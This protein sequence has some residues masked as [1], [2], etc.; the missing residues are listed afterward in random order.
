MRL[1]FDGYSIGG[2]G[3]GE[4]F[5]E[6]MKIVKQQK[7]ILPENKPVYLM[8]IGSPNEILEAISLGCD[9]F[10]SRMPTQNARHG[11]L[12]TSLGK[13]KI[14]NKKYTFDKTPIDKKCDCFVCKNYSKAYIRHLLKEE[15]AVGKEL[16]SYHNL[17][18]LQNMIKE[19][20]EAI[21]KGKFKEYKEKIKKV[22]GR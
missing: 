11:E 4:T 21:K 18:Y 2:F 8:G 16:A 14:L 19:A 22:Y 13:L 10:D 9:I 7:Q 12:F 20:K 5:E 15:E 3:M 1:G 6:E 17:Y